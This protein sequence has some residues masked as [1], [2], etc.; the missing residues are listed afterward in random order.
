MPFFLASKQVASKRLFL[1]PGSEGI[2][3]FT[4]VGTL[5]HI[6]GYSKPAMCGLD[7]KDF[8]ELKVALP[9]LLVA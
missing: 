1:F 8:T 3:T 2:V 5:W 7:T 4:F 6:L 9:Q